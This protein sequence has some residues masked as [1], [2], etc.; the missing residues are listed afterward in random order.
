MGKRGKR[1][2]NEAATSLASRDRCVALGGVLKGAS[3]YSGLKT[4]K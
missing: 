4:M 3:R 2:L 1:R